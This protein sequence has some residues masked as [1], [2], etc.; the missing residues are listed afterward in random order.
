M[1]VLQQERS[2]LNAHERALGMHGVTFS[3]AEPLRF[4]ETTHNQR[5]PRL[6][7]L[8]RLLQIKMANMD[9]PSRLV[10]LQKSPS[11]N[12]AM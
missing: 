9:R 4:H 2:V 10:N 3:H 11:S 6:L 12:K 8:V 7:V 1:E 5:D